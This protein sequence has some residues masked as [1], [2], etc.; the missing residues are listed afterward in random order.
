M[1]LFEYLVH[2]WLFREALWTKHGYVSCNIALPESD[3]EDEEADKQNISMGDD[4]EDDVTRIKTQI[5]YVMGDVTRPQKEEGDRDA[6]VV[7]CVGRQII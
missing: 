5:N 3:N 7:H 6:I 1:F 4:D 2:V